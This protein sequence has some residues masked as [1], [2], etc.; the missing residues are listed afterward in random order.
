M[1]PDIDLIRGR[2]N[3]SYL[4]MKNP[5]HISDF[6]RKNGFWGDFEQS[7]CKKVIEKFVAPMAIIDA[8][9]NLGGFSIP[10]AR[11]LAATGGLVHSFEPQRV[12]FQQLNANI[13]INRIDNVITYPMALGNVSK[14]IEIPELDFTKSQNAGGFSLNQEYRS[15]LD[16]E[17]CSGRNFKNYIKEKNVSIR[18]IR[19]DEL[20]IK[21]IGFIKAD[22]EG[23]E[24]EFFEG[25]QKSM[26]NSEFPPILFE[27][28]EGKSWYDTKAYLTKEFLINLG[29]EIHQFGRELLALHPMSPLYFKVRRA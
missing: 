15:E 9:A 22:V 21:S 8:G 24:L 11:A 7:V 13:F 27:V 29:Y 4:L 6:I 16:A 19:L 1:L 26:E 18:Q 28:W 23:M 12:V 2:D 5:D 17:A 25:A 14:N 10:V 3:N 20:D